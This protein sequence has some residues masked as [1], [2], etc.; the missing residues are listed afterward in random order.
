MGTDRD[1]GLVE[2]KMIIEEIQYEPGFR[3]SDFKMVEIPRKPFHSLILWK[4]NKRLN[5]IKIPNNQIDECAV[6]NKN[7]AWMKWYLMKAIW[8]RLY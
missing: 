1:E 8:E 5:P 4:G 2:T 3:F 7:R 6:T